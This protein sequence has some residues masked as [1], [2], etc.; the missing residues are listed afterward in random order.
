[1]NR[2]IRD[3]LTLNG[4]AIYTRSR[5]EQKVYDRLNEKTIEVFLPLI[6]PNLILLL[7]LRL[8]LP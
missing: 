5:H 3:N 8:G 2:F 4:Y 6:E 1:M 7:S